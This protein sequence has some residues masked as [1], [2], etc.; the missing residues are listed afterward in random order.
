MNK[1]NRSWRWSQV[2]ALF[3]L[4]AAVLTMT[5]P[6]RGGGGMVKMQSASVVPLLT[7]TSLAHGASF[8]ARSLAPRVG[9]SREPLFRSAPE[10]KQLVRREIVVR[11]VVSV[12]PLDFHAQRTGWK[13]LTKEVRAGLDRLALAAGVRA[14]ELRSTGTLRGDMADLARRVKV[15]GGGDKKWEQLGAAILVGNGRGA[16]DGNV[17]VGKCEGSVEGPLALYLVGDFNQMGVTRLQWEA[18]DEVIDYL[19][20]KWGAVRV[21]VRPHVEGAVGARWGLGTLFPT[22]QFLQAMVPPRKAPAE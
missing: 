17:Q 19:E 21:S 6:F 10:V 1:R 16:A 2:L 3:V 11:K 20:I 22:E 4:A 13:H 9:F 5:A 7:T 14:L 15:L 8:Q 12:G 18:L